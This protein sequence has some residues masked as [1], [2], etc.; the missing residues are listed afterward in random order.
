MDEATALTKKAYNEVDIFAWSNNL[1]QYADELKIDLFLFNKNYTV[2]R[3]KMA[4][5]VA[6]QLRALCV[7]DIMEYLLDGSET[8]LMVRDFELAESESGVL[9]KTLLSNVEKLSYTLNWLKNDMHNVETFVDSEHDLS[10][11]KGV[12]ARCFHKDMDEPFYIVKSIPGSMVMK[13][14]SAWMYKDGSFKP[15]DDMVAIKVPKDNQLLVV[16]DELFVFNQSKLKSLFGYDAKAAVIALQKVKE[17]ET[18]FHLSFADGA[19]LQ[20]LVMGKPST[21][22]KLQ[23]LEIGELKQEDIISHAEEMGIDLMS[24]GSGAILIM[25][26]KDLVKFVNLINDDYVESSLTG[27]RYE[28]VSKRPLKIKEPL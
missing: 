22:K 12:V 9:Q 21:I 25:D 13:G 18:S 8:G 2:Y 23:K 17:I 10:R 4:S 24:D 16:G 27:Q 11:M 7:D 19:T 5:D 26:D 3:V 28:V 20:S 14:V 1:V 15:F 6:K